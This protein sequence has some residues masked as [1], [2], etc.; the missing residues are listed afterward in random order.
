MWYGP[1]VN[2]CEIFI[3]NCSLSFIANVILKIININK[4]PNVKNYT[5]KENHEKTVGEREDYILLS[6]MPIAVFDMM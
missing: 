5:F 1:P 3:N 2:I 6:T 4:Y